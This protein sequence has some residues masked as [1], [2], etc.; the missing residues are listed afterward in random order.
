MYIS[1]HLCHQFRIKQTS[2][3]WIV[4]HKDRIKMPIAIKSV[5]IILLSIFKILRSYVLILFDRRDGQVWWTGGRDGQ[6]WW[7]DV[8][9]ECRLWNLKDLV[10]FRKSFRQPFSRIIP[11]YC[12][13]MANFLFWSSKIL[14]KKKGKDQ[15]CTLTMHNTSNEPFFS[16]ITTVVI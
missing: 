6:T 9:E 5:K 7:K 15:F 3:W 4:R 13:G 10:F 12:L 14:N 1:F 11:K 16:S 2:T 8:T